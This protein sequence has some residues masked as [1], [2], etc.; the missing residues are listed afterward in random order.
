LVDDGTG[1]YVWIN[2]TDTEEEEDVSEPDLSQDEYNMD[3]EEFDFDDLPSFYKPSTPASYGLQLVAS[4]FHEKK[5]Y[6]EEWDPELELIRVIMETEP[7][8]GNDYNDAL[9][10]GYSFWRWR[11]W[12]ICLGAV[13]AYED[14]GQSAAIA[15]SRNMTTRD[16]PDCFTERPI[17]L[18]SIMGEALMRNHWK[19]LKADLIDEWSEEGAKPRRTELT[20]SSKLGV[21]KYDVKTVMTTATENDGVY[22]L[23]LSFNTEKELPPEERGRV[24]ALAEAARISLAVYK[25]CKGCITYKAK[26]IDV[27]FGSEN[28]G[29]TEW[30]TGMVLSNSYQSAT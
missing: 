15:L 1:N 14:R 27:E 4:I 28:W 17:P 2:N 7:P 26:Q 22:K 25:K 19:S 3:D 30:P 10:G 8:E 20:L 24:R 6:V 21:R 12:I 29:F 5:G 16:L 23:E 11:G 18:P 9:N 13:K